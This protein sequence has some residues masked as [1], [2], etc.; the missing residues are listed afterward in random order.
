VS[1]SYGEEHDWSGQWSSWRDTER[2]PSLGRTSVDE[3][4]VDHVAVKLD[5]HAWQR[6]AYVGEQ[7][8]YNDEP[9][10]A[11]HLELR[12]CGC[13]TTLCREVRRK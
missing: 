7:L 6:L 2:E 11:T 4:Q 13:G 9:G 12:N 3:C 10:A 1:D 8:T 5:E